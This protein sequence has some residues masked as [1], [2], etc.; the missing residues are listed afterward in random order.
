[1]AAQVGDTAPDFTLVHRI[2]EDPVRLSQEI[3]DRPV[4]LLFYPLAFSG[5][6]TE[7]VCMLTD[8]FDPWASVGAKVFGLSVDSPFVLKR[9]AEETGAPFPL[10]S[11]F[12]QDAARAYGVSND[13]FFGMK[14]VSNRSAFVIDSSGTIVYA[15]TSEDSD[16]LPPF[17]DVLNA[18]RD[19][20]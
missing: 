2:G 9:F 12:N 5:V 16:L 8:N 19:A 4:V 17:D 3:G 13:D 1:M 18:V 6:C 20:Q 10:L 14:G 11:D 7:E 15:W